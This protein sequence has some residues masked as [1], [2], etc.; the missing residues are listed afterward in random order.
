MTLDELQKLEQALAENKE[1]KVKVY[2]LQEENKMLKE[3]FEHL[4]KMHESL[5]DSYL[6]LVNTEQKFNVGQ[7]VLVKVAGRDIVDRVDRVGVVTEIVTDK[8]D[9]NGVRRLAYKIGGFG[10]FENRQMTFYPWEIR[11][12][13]DLVYKIANAIYDARK[14]DLLEGM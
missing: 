14:N 12:C 7:V 2:D 11:S 9:D 3:N 4:N 8:I 1:L 5:S 6:N 10:R 13:E